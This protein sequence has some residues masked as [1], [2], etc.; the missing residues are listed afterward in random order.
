MN[1][2]K[3]ELR[4][5]IAWPSMRVPCNLPNRI[6]RLSGPAISPAMTFTKRL[7]KQLAPSLVDVLCNDDRVERRHVR[8]LHRR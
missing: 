3:N 7:Q 5:A 8:T 1:R 4:Y 2:V 6:V